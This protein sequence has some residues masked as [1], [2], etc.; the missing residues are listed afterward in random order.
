MAAFEKAR[1][2][3]PAIQARPMFGYP[4]IFLNGNHFAGTFRDKIVVR[5]GKEPSFPGARR[6]RP[7]EPM[8]GRAMT[9]Y[10]V[11][12]DA[13][14][15]SAAK[16]REWID[17]AHAYAKTLPAKAAKTTG[18]KTAKPAKKTRG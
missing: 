6:A 15:K 1:P 3:D 17:R 16:L 2:D 18:T 10:L 8:P 11:V 14:V 13:D 5:V 9:G 12:P 7:F 4:A